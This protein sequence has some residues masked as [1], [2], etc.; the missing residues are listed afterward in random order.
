[1]SAAARPRLLLLAGVLLAVLLIPFSRETI[2]AEGVLGPSTHLTVE[3]PESGTV[4]A[5]LVRE[6]DPVKEG[7]VL[8]RMSSSAVESAAARW[9][10]IRDRSTKAASAARVEGSASETYAGERHTLSA[11]AGLKSEEARLGRLTVRSPLSGRILTPRVE[12]LEKRHVAAGTL[13]A[14]VGDCRTLVAAL[15]VSE[16]LLDELSVGAPV[17]AYALQRPL[18]PIHGTVKRIAPATAGQP[19]TAVEG[20]EPP[21]PG[22]MPERFVALA[23]FDNPD[24][25]LRPGS[26][27]RVKIAGPRRSYAARVLRVVGRWMRTVFW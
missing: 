24:E 22:E 13:L 23:F 4:E 20:V 5:V 15:P 26:P 6:S 11:E 25:T 27:V 19:K 21:L 1:M 12:D 17:K 18:A 2:T 9:T 8:F 3:A 16:R 14:E 7:D 10:G